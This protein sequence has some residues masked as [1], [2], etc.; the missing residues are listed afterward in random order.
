MTR[1]QIEYAKAEL[2]RGVELE[3]LR[4]T[5]REYG[6]DE[7]LIIN[8]LA[9]AR[10]ELEAEASPSMAPIPAPTPI[11]PVAEPEP[12]QEMK[13]PEPAPGIS[14]TPSPIPAPIPV[15]I[16]TNSET[17]PEQ[18]KDSNILLYVVIALAVGIA[19]MGMFV[20]ASLNDARDSGLN[21]SAQ[22]M[23]G[24]ARSMAEI[25]YN[26]NGDSY[27][28]YCES[29]DFQRVSTLEGFTFECEDSASAYRASV[30][31][32]PGDSGLRYWCIDSTGRAESLPT[33]PSGLS[34]Q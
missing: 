10:A 12:V 28:G 27:A 3:T 17:A 11:T 33:A 14:Q 2:L 6:Y 22:Q 13:E 23:L 25:Y 15:P 9:R 30:R 19:G 18:E 21:A 8:L 34:C 1:E 5:L 32:I 20:M 31:L 29:A 16:P 7:E 26:E 4:A 24:N